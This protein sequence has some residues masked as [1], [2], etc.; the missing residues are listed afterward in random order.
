MVFLA[1]SAHSA[2]MQVR[3]PNKGLHGTPIK[4]LQLTLTESSRL[5]FDLGRVHSRKQDAFYSFTE[6]ETE[7]K[8]NWKQLKESSVK[9]LK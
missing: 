1:H 4:T 2:L 7:K 3:L 9:P 5:F 6:E 8:E